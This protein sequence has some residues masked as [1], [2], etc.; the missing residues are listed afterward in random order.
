MNDNL[1]LT[2]YHPSSYREM[3]YVYPVVSRRSGGL[4]IGVNLSP[5]SQCNFAC[6]YCQVLGDL[7][8][9]LQN[10]EQAFQDA[11]RKKDPRQFSPL[12]DLDRLEM[13]L[14]ELVSAVVNG[15]LFNEDWFNQ[16]PSEKRVLQ[17]I[18][19]SGDGEPTLNAQFP[20]VVR[21]V[22]EIRKELCPPSTKLVV[23]T[24]A[25]KLDDPHVRNALALLKANHGEIWAKLDAGT[26]EFYK[27]V[28]RSQVPFAQILENLKTAAKEFPLVVQSCFLAIHGTPPSAAELDAYV[29]RL[30][31]IVGSGGTIQRVQ[32]YTVARSTP[33]RWATPLADDVMNEIAA[34]V[35]RETDLAVET[36]YTR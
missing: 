2:Q 20:E 17:D 4:S 33:E 22:V 10:R 29:E 16:T 31:E 18:A 15:N 9:R 19:F 36:F 6:V 12:V 8:A 3:K 25:T 21:R 30:R 26:E 7:E 24:N 23:I 28:S 32:L 1:A 35:R 11:E 5:T 34:K 14:R 13:E 27:T